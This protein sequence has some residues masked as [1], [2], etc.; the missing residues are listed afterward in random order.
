MFGSIL[1][2]T[3]TIAILALLKEV[4]ASKSLNSLIEGESLLNDGTSMILFEI[5]SRIVKGE[6]TF[7]YFFTFFYFQKGN[8]II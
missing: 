2:C 5:S 3:D 7:I 8:V 6:V 4:G 1:S